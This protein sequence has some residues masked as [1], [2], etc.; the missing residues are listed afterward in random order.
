MR[1]SKINKSSNALF[2]ST[3][4]W[5]CVVVNSYLLFSD[6]GLYRYWNK[7]EVEKQD[8]RKTIGIFNKRKSPLGSK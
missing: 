8:A 5:L 4:E 2:L 1:T 6:F 3:D 7:T